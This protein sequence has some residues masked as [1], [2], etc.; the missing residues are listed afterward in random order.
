MGDHGCLHRNF[1]VQIN[2][3]MYR[4]HKCVL[5]GDEQIGRSSAHTRKSSRQVLQAWDTQ[6]SAGLTLDPCVCDAA[7]ITSHRPFPQATALAP[8]PPLR[9]VPT[10]TDCAAV[11]PGPQC[12]CVQPDPLFP[13]PTQTELPYLITDTPKL[14]RTAEHEHRVD[15]FYIETDHF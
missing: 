7:G 10:C 8:S 2:Y 13:V 1:C 5:W 15:V 11:L 14:R 3:T 9:H 12:P 4:G 6:R